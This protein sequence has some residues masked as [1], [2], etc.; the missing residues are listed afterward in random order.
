MS[1]THDDIIGH[2]TVHM[3]DSAHHGAEGTVIKAKVS[4]THTSLLVCINT[5]VTQGAA[6]WLYKG[7][8]RWCKKT[9]HEHGITVNNDLT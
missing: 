2:C 3:P 4:K 9:N 8:V 1:I 6:V 7:N 5:G